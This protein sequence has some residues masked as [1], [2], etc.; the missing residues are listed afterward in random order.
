MGTR[1][2]YTAGLAVVVLVSA[3]ATS[4]QGDLSTAT[5][6]GDAKSHA[7]DSGSG[8]GSSGGDDSSVPSGDDGAAPGD[9]V[10]VGD[11]VTTGDDGS[12]GDDASACAATCPSGCCDSTGACQDGTADDVC[13]TGGATCSDC[14]STGGTCKSG[15]C[16]G[17]AAPMYACVTTLPAPAPVC[18]SKH[19]SCLC[20]D[21]SQCNSN[22]LN[23]VNNGGCN[24][25]HCPGTGKCNGGQFVDSAGCSVVAPTCNLGGNQG[26][27]AKTTCEVNHGGCGGAVQCCWCTSDAACP[28]GGKCVNDPTQKQCDGQGPCS[29]SGSSFDGMHCQLGSPGIPLCTTQ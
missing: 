16:S 20:T 29:G 28:V 9:D 1:R 8:S 4:G 12:G 14:T 13:G 11:D 6:G 10:T 3:C 2:A 23:V 15:A 19:Q 17:A 25:K 26:C 24:S 22:G 7:V 5:G 18:D 21:N 27:P